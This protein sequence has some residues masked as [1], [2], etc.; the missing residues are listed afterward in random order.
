MYQ[1][2][3]YDFAQEL[4]KIKSSGLFKDE[5]TILSAQKPEIRVEYPAGSDP[6]NV[7]NFCANNYLGLANHPK[8]LEAARK[9]LDE[10]GFGLASVRFICGTQ[11]LHKILE[12][13]IAEFFHTEDTIL[14][15]SCFDA[16][17][18]LFETLLG[19][20]DAV[21][22]D[23]LNH[24]SIIDGIRLCK[25][26]RFIYDHA[27]MASLEKA[28]KKAREGMDVWDGPGLDKEPVPARNIMIITDG[29]FS[30]D[31][32]VAD[33]RR[34]VE[35]GNTYDT[36]VVVDD[37]HG[38]GVLG[39]TGRGSVEEAGMLGQVD[40]ITSTLGK[41]MGGATGGFVTGHREIIEILRQKSRPYLFS[42]TIPPVIAA[43]GIAAFDLLAQGQELREKLRD[44]TV[45]FRGAMKALGFDIIDGSHPI[46]PVMFRKF[47]NDARLAQQMAR[48]LYA[49]GIYVVGF[50]Y[51]VV[52]KGQSRI[53]VQISAA[54]SREQMER[55]VAAFEKVGRKLEV[56]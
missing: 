17:G 54:H 47:D 36:L 5:R 23:A 39:A 28:L 56:I 11:D 25:A 40:I 38:T 9:A 50:V 55:A 7:L 53:R 51:P 35:L 32:D 29:V 1:R 33:I 10:H 8:I 45:F 16:N 27:D 48:E 13:K 34:I 31:G 15:S 6:R 41:A 20:E 43:A 24:A 42:N 26:K 19:V 12:Q 3:K 30:M 4:V 22:T 44:N 21:V 52:P 37:S 14:Y 49:E 46:V 2:I 18:G